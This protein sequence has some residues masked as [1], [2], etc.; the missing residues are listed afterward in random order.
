MKISFIIVEFYSVEDIVTCHSLII[1]QVPSNWFCE[2]IVSSNSVYSLEQ[3]DRLVSLD[4][5]L[6]WVFNDK[7]G[8]FAYAMN[9]GLAIATGDIFVIMNPDVRIKYDIRKMVNYLYLHNEIGIIAPKIVDS[10]GKIQDSFRSFITPTNFIKRH[11]NRIFKQANQINLYESPTQTDWVI[12]AFMMMPRRVYEAVKGLDERYFLYCED[13][14]IC[15]RVYLQGYSVVYY[16]EVKIEYE[17]TRSARKS[18]KY[19][20]IFLRS[21]LRYWKKFGFH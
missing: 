4:K 15:K 16:P 14:D 7:N 2:V 8:G 21:L 5:T 17:G 9:Q 10:N 20:L 11:L 19:A 1:D 12:G 13:M 6:R 3:Q 18:W